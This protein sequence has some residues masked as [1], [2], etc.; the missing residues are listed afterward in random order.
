MALAAMMLICLTLGVAG[1][2]QS[3]VNDPADR[4]AAS[5]R[6][7]RTAEPRWSIGWSRLKPGMD[8]VDV[9][10]LLD[11]P[12]HVKVSRINTTWYYSDRQADGPYVVFG[13]REM[14]VESWRAPKAP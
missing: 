7:T 5:D 6:E 11:E 12:K 13:T 8:P 4:P 3:T 1:C 9:L 10:D 2:S 14:R